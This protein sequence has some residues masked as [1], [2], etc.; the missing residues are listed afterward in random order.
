MGICKWLFSIKYNPKKNPIT[1]VIPPINDANLKGNTEKPVANFIN[2][3]I[4]SKSV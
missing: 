3:L 4:D 1:E 2:T